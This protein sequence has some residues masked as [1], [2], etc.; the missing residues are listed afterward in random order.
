MNNPSLP[1][2]PGMPI[3]FP[4]RGTKELTFTRENF[5]FPIVLQKWNDPLCTL[6]GKGGSGFFHST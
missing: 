1:K 2:F 5:E 4:S 6:F 3:L